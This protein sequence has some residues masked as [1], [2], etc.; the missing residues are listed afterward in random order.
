M[1][2]KQIITYLNILIGEN[3]LL[4]SEIDR[5]KRYWYTINF[6][7]KYPALILI[8]LTG[9]L[10]SIAITQ[11]HE[12]IQV[13]ILVLSGLTMVLNITH[14]F[15]N[16]QVQ[17]ESSKHMCELL[18]GLNCQ[19]R[20]SCNELISEDIVDGRGGELDP[21][22]VNRYL[23]IITKFELNRS[24][25]MKQM[26]SKLFMRARK[27]QIELNLP[28]LTDEI[29]CKLR[30]RRQSAFDFSS[31]DGEDNRMAAEDVVRMKRFS[32]GRSINSVNRE[33]NADNPELPL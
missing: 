9:T 6:V 18:D 5:S 3:E 12:A 17:I 19:L 16:P 32:G 28:G 31:S 2:I 10:A 1:K 4:G 29:I 24:Y 8:G 14:S 7:L 20:M 15:M 21:E 13:T 33:F 26:P 30:D 11:Y 22:D 27:A 25:I 23:L